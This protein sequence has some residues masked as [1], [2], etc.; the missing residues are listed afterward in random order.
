MKTTPK[1]APKTTCKDETTQDGGNDGFV[2]LDHAATSPPLGAA[3]AEQRTATEKYVGN[4]S[5]LHPLGEAARQAL[6]AY[7]KRFLYALKRDWANVADLYEVVF[8]SG[9]TEADGMAVFGSCF[10]RRRGNVVF[11]AVEHPAI[12]QWKQLLEQ[13]KIEVRTVAVDRFGRVDPAAVLEAVDAQTVL[14]SLMAVNNELGTVQPVAEVSAAIKKTCPRAVFHTDA[15]QG[16]GIEPLS[17][18]GTHVDLVSFS[19]HKIAGPRGCGALLV[20][21]GLALTP[22][23]PG[24]GQQNG[25]RSGTENLPAI[26]GFVRAVEL[27]LSQRAATRATLHDLKARAVEWIATNV[28]DARINGPAIFGDT[29]TAGDCAAMASPHILSVSVP[30]IAS[31]VLTRALAER[32]VCVSHGSAC[33]ARKATPSSVLRAIGVDPSWGT[34]R[35]SFCARTT[36]PQ[37]AQGLGAW[38]EAIET[39]RL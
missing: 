33:H 17:A 4:P 24:G 27:A 15:V 18:L 14:V 36:W 39:Y 6:A 31:A 32:S 34:V 5:S 26:A 28:P 38:A 35:F 8:T 20:R 11:S 21:S 2:Y 12:W 23:L 7:H 19:S 1:T 37:V 16:L 10:A 29:T 3:I 9:G 13:C 30:G 25:R 22:L